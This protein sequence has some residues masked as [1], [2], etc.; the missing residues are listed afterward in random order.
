MTMNI[1]ELENTVKEILFEIMKDVK[2][3]KIDQ[4]NMI[5]EFD[6]DAHA[7]QIVTAFIDYEA[8]KHFSQ[9]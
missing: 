4:D 1:F 3:H 8:S 9:S 2:V 6:Y 5:L 7:K